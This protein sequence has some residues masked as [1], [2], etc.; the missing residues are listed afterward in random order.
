MK[1][2]SFSNNLFLQDI[3]F[4]KFKELA[5]DYKMQSLNSSPSRGDEFHAEHALC[6]PE[7]ALT[8]PTSTTL[9]SSP[10]SPAEE[11]LSPVPGPQMS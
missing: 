9:H 10:Y 7:Q 2:C 1:P 3:F 5:N 8:T 6:L 4:H 11:G